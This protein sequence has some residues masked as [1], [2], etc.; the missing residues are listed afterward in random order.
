M[1]CQDKGGGR[2]RIYCEEGGGVD[3]NPGKMQNMSIYLSGRR[4]IHQRIPVLGIWP[5]RGEIVE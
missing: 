5:K 2:D 3:D 4:K 1:G